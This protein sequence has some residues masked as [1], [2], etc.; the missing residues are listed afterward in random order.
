MKNLMYRK[1]AKVWTEALPLGNGRLGAMH[2]GGVEVEQFQLNE[3]T[4]WSG[5][6]S[7]DK[8]YDDRE[9]LKKVRK[10]IDEENY[11][12]AIS[13][14]KNMFG[15]YTQSYMPLGDMKI[16]FLHGN[17]ARNYERSLD[18]RQAVSSVKYSV[19]NVHFKREAFISY[20]HQVLAI[21]LT[22]SE[23]N[24][25][26]FD[27][28]L[29]SILKNRTANSEN[30]LIL[31]GICPEYCAP[32][33]FNEDKQ[34]IVYG[35]FEETKAIH[36]EGRL[37]V[38]IDAGEKKI[39]NGKIS[40]HNASKATIYF[41][42]ATSFNGFDQL[43]G[44]YF[45]DLTRKNEE[46]LAQAMSISYEQLKAEHI[47]DYQSLYNRVEL[48]LECNKPE[49]ILD[50]DER[51]KKNGS[52]DLGMV[53]LLFQYGRYLLI[54]SSR[55]GT[56]PANLQ[57]IWNDLTR[58]PWSSNYTVNINA[59]MNYWPAEITNLA[60]CHRPLLKLVSELAVNGERM[61]SDRYGLRGWT[62]HH[63]TDLWRHADPVG[64]DRHGDPI[65]AFWPMS[66]PWLCR[67]L[68]EHFSFSQDRTFLETEALPIMK[69]AA[70][71]CLDWLIEDENGYLT[72]SP[73]T[74]PEHL[75]YT[76]K[77][78]VGSVTKGATMDLQIIWDLFTNCIEAAAVLDIEDEWIEN[79]KHARERLYPMQIGKYGQLQEWAIDYED[80]EPHHRHVSHLYGVYPGTQITEGPLLDAVKQ[81]LNRRGDMGTGW[82]LGWKICL[83]ARLKDG[84]RVNALFQQLFNIVEA[85][86]EVFVGGGIY[87]N[88]LGA[89]PPFQIDGNFSY[90]AGVVEMIIQSHKG[91]VELLPALPSTWIKGSINGIRVQ[92]GF[93]VNVSWDKL[94]VTGLKVTSNTE[95]LFVFKSC[96]SVIIREE[97]RDDKRL[98][99]IDG[100]IEIDMSE[101]QTY[102]LLF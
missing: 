80:V 94:R 64:G 19:G 53:E 25:L 92:G 65:W 73:S 61:V 86:N 95:N 44:K 79:V 21:Q 29:E 90:T 72:T 63:N 76:D 81:T 49:E 24:S 96:T 1:A 30:E 22:S 70:E 50:T 16:H 71:F 88:L 8:K 57:G 20:P 101:N 100:L 9:S 75:F 6:P 3:D 7:K 87:P 89:H 68:W 4:L 102:Q 2:F 34:P 51:V 13:E 48:S 41:S 37:G 39:Q 66:G 43:P 33:Y 85:K 74:S 77:G 10:L 99:P 11:E 12:E 40:I 32:N 98:D 55:E 52:S 62:A 67:H 18:I 84:E 91:Y 82:S 45:G 27:I 60:E 83:W 28:L 38:V 93:E 46:I 42:V 59:E 97:G 47:R 54:S 69:G 35:E 17:I 26:H 78:Q 56:Q 15:S 58:A 14:T 36:F 5:P 31:Q 23:E